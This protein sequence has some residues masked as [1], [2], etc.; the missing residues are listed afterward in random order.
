MAFTEQ[1]VEEIVRNAERD[2]APPSVAMRLE[3]DL[4]EVLHAHR[5][6]MD[7]IN[8]HTEV[9]SIV[10]EAQYN[11]TRAAEILGVTREAIYK[12]LRKSTELPSGVDG[13]AA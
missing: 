12:H 13:K 8:R 9:L 11:V 3:A 6:R 1:T 7:R 4:A 5:R 10:A 2:G